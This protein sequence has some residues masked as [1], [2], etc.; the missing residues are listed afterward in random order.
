MEEFDIY[1]DIRER[2]D[3]NVYFGVVGPVRAGK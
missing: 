3:G 2:T 1:K